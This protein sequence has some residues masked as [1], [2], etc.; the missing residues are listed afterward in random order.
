[1]MQ[2]LR[3]IPKNVEFIN[4][5]C[6]MLL[7]NQLAEWVRVKLEEVEWQIDLGIASPDG[8]D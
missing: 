6:K 1:M 4:D 7:M 2:R 5:W 3:T 8:N